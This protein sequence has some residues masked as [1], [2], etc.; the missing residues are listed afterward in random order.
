VHAADE[1]VPVAALDFG[2]R[3]VYQALRTFHA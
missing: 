3:A 1:R 2:M